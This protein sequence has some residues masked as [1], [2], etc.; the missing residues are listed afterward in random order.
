MIQ[1]VTSIVSSAANLESHTLMM[2]YGGPDIFFTRLAPSKG[3]D[4]LPETFNR[5]LLLVI[6]MSLLIAIRVIFA[7]SKRKLVAVGWV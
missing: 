3:F 6:M 2:A 5:I 7:K 1:A 4:S